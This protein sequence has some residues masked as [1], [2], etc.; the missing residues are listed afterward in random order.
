MFESEVITICLLFHMS[1]FRCFKYLD[2]FYVQKHL[3]AEF[4]RTV[5]YNRFTELRQ[6]VLMP[7]V[8][9]LKTCYLG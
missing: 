6:G 5:S 8:I 7:M 3:K 9:L 1:G 2:L 4:P